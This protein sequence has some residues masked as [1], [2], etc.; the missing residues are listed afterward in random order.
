MQI[1]KANNFSEYI[2]IIKII[3]KK[4]KVLWFRGH[5]NENFQL[6][7]SLLRYGRRKEFRSKTVYYP[8]MISAIQ[9]F[10]KLGRGLPHDLPENDLEWLFLMQ[11]YGVP[12]K[13]L[14]WSSN[15]LIGLFFSLHEQ[16][17]L[18]FEIT[19][20]NGA[21]F[22]VSPLEINEQAG[23]FK[24]DQKRM[25]DLSSNKKLMDAYLASEDLSYSQFPICIKATYEDVRIR[26]QAGVFSLHGYDVRP[27]EQ[28]YPFDKIIHKIL[29]PYENM[30]SFYHEL[31]IR[32]ITNSFIYPDLGSIAKM[33]KNIIITNFSKDYS[34][35]SQDDERYV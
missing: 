3:R 5:P 22:V 19:P 23:I 31:S 13:L 24:H 10:K 20:R 25:I 29:I 7:P 16:G 8:N 27:L 14:D 32:G 30:K 34:S 12:T 26:N 21:V 28:F 15:E 18:D 1:H 33:T 2:E 9:H 35:M 17:L 11:H 6:I 4:N